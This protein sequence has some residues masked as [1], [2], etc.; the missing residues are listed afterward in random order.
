MF[1]WSCLAFSDVLLVF[2]AELIFVT[3]DLFN[4]NI[5]GV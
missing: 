3:M 1:I 4:A 2:A 5:D